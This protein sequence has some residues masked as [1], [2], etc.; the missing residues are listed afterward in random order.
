MLILKLLSRVHSPPQ[1]PP[2]D[3]YIALLTLDFSPHLLSWNR[4][5]SHHYIHLA[6]LPGHPSECVLPTIITNKSFALTCPKLYLRY[7]TLGALLFTDN[8]QVTE[9]AFKQ[10]SLHSFSLPSSV[11]ISAATG[12]TKLVEQSKA[13]LVKLQHEHFCLFSELSF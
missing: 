10:L 7:Y 12:G 1:P 3:A 9:V 2:K 6:A 5:K 8:T 4:M 13:A 11:A